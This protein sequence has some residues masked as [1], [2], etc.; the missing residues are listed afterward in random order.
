MEEVSTESESTGEFN[1]H[2]AAEELLS[3]EAQAD[4]TQAKST[5]GQ[6]ETAPKETVSDEQRA[7]DILDGKEV[8]VENNKEVKPGE[9]NA[10]LEQVNALKMAWNGQPIKLETPEQ[11]AEMIQKGFDY[12][13]KTM[14]HA[15]EVKQ[16]Q[17]QSAKMQETY[18]QREQELHGTSFKNNI[19]DTMVDKWRESDP[20]LYNYIQDAFQR[21]IAEF[22]KNQPIIA[23]YEGK[24]KELENKFAELEQGKQKE[25]L[26]GIKGTWEKELGELQSNRAAK[27][28]QL[29][30]TP[31]WEKVKAIWSSDNSNTMTAEKALLAVHGAEMIK[32]AESEMSRLK[33]ANAAY[34]SKN[35]RGGVSSSHKGN[36]TISAKSMGDYMSIL[37]QEADQI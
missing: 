33:K 20:D 18:Q 21:E 7:Q 34:S 1:L 31:D 23:Q 24:F 8:A 27:L 30:I 13:K 32:A 17:E 9:N 22:Q 14:A 4:S 37:R 19:V 3:N 15:E 28:K 36:E 26:E 6:P 11:V 10:L 35:G 16:W 25:T 5:D 29:G 2:E 12:T